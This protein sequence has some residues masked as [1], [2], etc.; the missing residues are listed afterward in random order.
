MLL[1]IGQILAAFWMACGEASEIDQRA[2]LD[3]MELNRTFDYLT[4]LGCICLIRTTKANSQ[5]TE[6]Q[7]HAKFGEAFQFFLLVV[8]FIDSE[9]KGEH[10][11][12]YWMHCLFTSAPSPVA[13][14]S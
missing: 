14:V 5:Q 11:H 8:S 7:L 12:K 10:G 9:L 6:T 13:R 1:R 4:W 3:Y 2:W